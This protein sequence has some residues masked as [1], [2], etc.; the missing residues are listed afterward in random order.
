MDLLNPSID[1]AILC[2][3]V[4]AAGGKL[5]L[6]G[7]GWDNLFVAKFPARHH[8][9]G[10]GLRIRIPWGSLDENVQVHVDLIDEDGQSILPAGPL[11]HRIRARRN[12]ALEEGSDVGVVRAF[13]FNNLEFPKAGPY[14]FV[15]T[16][17]DSVHRLGFNVRPRPSSS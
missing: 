17:A 8:T 12:P 10:I 7:G 9:L 4:Q 13:T 14:A 1:F 2:D 15:L 5:H 6:V 11:R 16:M 3:A